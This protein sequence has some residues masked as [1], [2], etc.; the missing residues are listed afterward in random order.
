MEKINHWKELTFESLTAM[1]E[2]IMTALPSLIGAILILI[3]GWIVTKIV[4]FIIKKIL[5]VA[6]I[7]LLN[8]KINKLDLFGKSSIDLNITKAILIFAKWILY[9]VF[10]IIAADIMNWSIVSIEIGNL[11]RYLPKLFSAIALFM[12]GVYIAK[13]VRDAIYSLCSS[14]NI[15]GGKLIS[16]IVFYIISIIVTL[17]A[18][19]QAGIDTTIITN[20]ITIILG[21]FLLAMAIG[22]GLGS[23]EIVADL[24]RSFYSRKTYEIGDHIKVNDVV[25]TIVSVDNLSMVI[26]TQTGKVIIPIKDITENTVEVKE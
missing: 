9:L 7:D 17:T 11:L 10:L 24:L 25:G 18:L 13:F 19:N 4:V 26:K 12:I 6:K 20:N 15:T 22:L 3:V 1:G 16:S 2:K 8:D 23:K 5:K 21:S 14:F